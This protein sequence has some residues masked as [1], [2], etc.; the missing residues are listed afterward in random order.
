MKSSCTS[1]IEDAQTLLSV[2]STTITVGKTRL[3]W[4]VYHGE[5]SGIKWHVSLTN[6]TAMPLKVVETTGLKQDGPI[7]ET[8]ED[9][10]FILVSD[11]AYFSI[12]KV[13]RY[14]KEKQDFVIRLKD[15]VQVNRKKS[16]KSCRTEDSNVMADFTCTLGTSQKQ[17]EKRHC[18]VECIDYE[19]KMMCVV[20]SLMNVTAGEIADMYKSRWAIESFFR[21]IKQYLNVPILFG[22]TPNAVFNQLFTAPTASFY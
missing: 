4:A 15:H 17:A 9:H 8:L 22:T 3:P 13:D 12:D 5:R 6:E 16:L 2:D 21:W 11:C 19:G 7:G 14:L 10:R 20:T 1:N 18:V